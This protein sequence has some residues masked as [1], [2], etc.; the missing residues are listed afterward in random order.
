MAYGS[1][2]TNEEALPTAGDLPEIDWGARGIETELGWALPAVLD[3]FIRSGTG[4]VADVPGGPRG[5]QVLVAITTEQ[6]SSQL[7]LAQRLGIDKTQMTYVVDALEQGGF[8]DRRPDPRDRR[9]RQVRPTEAGLVLVESARSALRATEGLLMRHLAP[10]EQLTLRRLLA[11][12]ALGAA[13]VPSSLPD[14]LAATDHPVAAPDR[15]RRV[16]DHAP[17]DRDPTP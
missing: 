14:Q 11:R 7:A 9:V 12:V 17:T 5:Y 2:M 4:A 15:S 1:S 8:V 3:G 13:D 6:P 16:R 10:D